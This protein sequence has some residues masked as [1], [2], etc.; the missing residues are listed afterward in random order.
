MVE[1][2][3]YA[4]PLYIVTCRNHPFVNSGESVDELVKLV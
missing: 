2:L 1:I 3:R 4:W